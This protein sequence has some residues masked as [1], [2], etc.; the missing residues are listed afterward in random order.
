[1]HGTHILSV[2]K[3]ILLLTF[4]LTHT[5]TTH[6]FTHIFNVQLLGHG[7]SRTFLLQLSLARA[8]PPPARHCSPNHISIFS[9]YLF[10]ATSPALL[11]P[12]IAFCT[13]RSKE[14]SCRARAPGMTAREHRRWFLCCFQALPPRTRRKLTQCLQPY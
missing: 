6:V 7:L 4:L 8:C 11:C 1:M 14:E 13:Q 5:H 9:P 3:H 10:L 2:E 12:I